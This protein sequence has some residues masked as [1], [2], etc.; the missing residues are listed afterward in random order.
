MTRQSY[1]WSQAH[2]NVAG[3]ALV[4]VQ[5]HGLLPTFP[6]ELFALGGV[7]D[8]GSPT[9]TWVF[10]AL[11]RAQ[12][13]ALFTEAGLS[14]SALTPTKTVE[15]TIW[16]AIDEDYEAGAGGFYNVELLRPEIESRMI[17]G[18]YRNVEFKFLVIEAA[19]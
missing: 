13:A 17:D 7:Y 9:V 19:S 2:D 4:S 16:T 12:M 10:S 6:E 14:M 8:N 15:M 3:L 18:Y 11:T 5:P 1:W